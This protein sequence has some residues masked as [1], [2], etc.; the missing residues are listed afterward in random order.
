MAEAVS[1]FGCDPMVGHELSHI[2]GRVR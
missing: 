2:V 1:R